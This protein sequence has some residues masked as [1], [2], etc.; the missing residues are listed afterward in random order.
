MGSQWGNE[1]VALSISKAG[2]HLGLTASVFR[3]LVSDHGFPVAIRTSGGHR[4]YPLEQ[5]DL[6]HTALHRGHAYP[7]AFGW[8]KR[9]WQ[10][11][12]DDLLACLRVCDLRSA[13]AII[14]DRLNLR[15]GDLRIGVARELYGAAR[16][17]EQ[18]APDD[19]TTAL[20]DS[21]TASWI[22]RIAGGLPS[23]HAASGVLLVDASARGTLAGV[24]LQMLA[25]ELAV[26][27]TPW[28][29]ITLPAERLTNL[30]AAVAAVGA[31]GVAATVLVG[32]R[33]PTQPLRITAPI[34]TLAR[35]PLPS[36]L[37][38]PSDPSAWTAAIRRTTTKGPVA[39][40][41]RKVS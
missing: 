38:M 32:D 23:P 9:T 37:P 22:E 13:D 15:T 2:S 14:S 41:L 27:R 20:A 17:L 33:D 24:A 7:V 29:S 21:W 34:F 30:A 19:A 12:T 18:E 36:T 3:G 28:V 10:S 35:E 39:R 11:R 1:S 5:L 31:D 25:L 6:I 16:V 4:R 8:A 26:D 40:A